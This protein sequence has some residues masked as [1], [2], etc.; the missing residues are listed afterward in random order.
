MAMLNDVL[1]VNDSIDTLLL[2][3][4]FFGLLFSILSLMAG[5][6]DVGGH[7]QVGSHGA[8]GGHGHGHG[9]G[10]SRS[11]ENAFNIVTIMAFLTWFG[12]STYLLR[13]GVGIPILL[14]LPLGIAIGAVGGYFVLRLLAWVKKQETPMDASLERLEG[15]VGRIT[16]PIRAGGVGELVYEMNGVRQVSA[17]RAPEGLAIARGTP[18][19]VLKRERG[20][21]LVEPWDELAP[22]DDWERR[23]STSPPGSIT[24]PPP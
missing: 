5:A 2:G 4:F 17:A 15:A 24:E 1:V 20:I 12:G 3:G 10:S 22:G 21:A 23:F 19:I 16:S 6:V 8:H 14:C 11:L 13:N 9:H 18:V 7:V